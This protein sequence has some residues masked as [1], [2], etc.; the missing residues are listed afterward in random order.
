[1][2]I[3]D[4][5]TGV[6]SMDSHIKEIRQEFEKKLSL[7]QSEWKED[8]K[9]GDIVVYSIKKWKGIGSEAA[10]WKVETSF[11]FKDK[12]SAATLFLANHDWDKRLKWDPSVTAKSRTLKKIDDH[13]SVDYSASAPA[14]GGLISTREFID[15]RCYEIGPDGGVLAWSG[16]ID[17]D[18]EE[19]KKVAEKGNVRGWNFPCGMRIS[20]GTGDKDWNMTI[21]WHTDLKGMLPKRSINAA[22]PSTMIAT[23]K[24]LKKL[25]V[26][27]GL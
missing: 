8:T 26:T 14:L 18:Q 27:L 13:V 10:L 24:N 23:V 1:M 7:P 12:D 21:V 19:V 20:K 5:S 4:R 11:T 22:I 6:P 3:R 17:Y 9:D 25:A 16:S 15:L 2:C